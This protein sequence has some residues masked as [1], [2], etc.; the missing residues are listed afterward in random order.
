[1]AGSLWTTD[2]FRELLPYARYSHDDGDWRLV[3][4]PDRRHV[5]YLGT[6]VHGAII[7]SLA[8]T[9]ACILVAQTTGK[10][11]MTK[12]IHM[13]LFKPAI[14]GHEIIATPTLEPQE[15]PWKQWIEVI[16]EQSG[17]TIA[18]ARILVGV[19]HMDSSL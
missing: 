12:E 2:C 15:I 8:D 6:V 14:L 10:I 9:A 18:K 17:D 4:I 16:L 19:M 13:S 7:T 5:N 3:L 1:M 11:C